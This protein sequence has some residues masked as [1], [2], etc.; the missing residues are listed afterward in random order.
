MSLMTPGM[1]LF[2]G[3]IGLRAVAFFMMV[4]LLAGCGGSTRLHLLLQPFPRLVS[5]IQSVR[6]AARS[7]GPMAYKSWYQPVH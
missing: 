3:A 5:R 7:Q 1:S 4:G 6:R 2:K